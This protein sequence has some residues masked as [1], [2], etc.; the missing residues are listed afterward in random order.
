MQVQHLKV[1]TQLQFF[2]WF[3]TRLTNGSVTEPLAIQSADHRYYLNVY[4][5][6]RFV[7]LA[8]S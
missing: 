6:D 3:I 5:A 4:G 2:S 8:Y 1:Y 7:R